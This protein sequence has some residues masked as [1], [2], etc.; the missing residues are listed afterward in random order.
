M[1]TAEDVLQVLDALRGDELND[2]EAEVLLQ[3]WSGERTEEDL[4]AACYA[5]LTSTC[6]PLRLGATVKAVRLAARSGCGTGWLWERLEQEYEPGKLSEAQMTNWVAGFYYLRFDPETY[7]RFVRMASLAMRKYDRLSIAIM[8]STWSGLGEREAE[9]TA[10][11][12][13]LAEEN[14]LA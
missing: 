13:K 12:E 10:Y 5:V 8:L 3:R 6:T 2:H 14:R 1:N 4:L 7:A 9:V 11:I